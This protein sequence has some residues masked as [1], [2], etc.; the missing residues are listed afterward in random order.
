MKEA[1]FFIIIGYLSGSILFAPLFGKLLRGRD[2]LTE[3]SDGNPGAANAFKYG[4]FWCGVLTLCGDMAKGFLPMHFYLRTGGRP[5]D[6]GVAACGSVPVFLTGASDQA[7]FLQNGV[8]LSGSK[9]RGKRTCRGDI[10][11]EALILSCSTGGGHNA[12][13]LAVKEEMERQCR[14]ENLY[15]CG[16]NRIDQKM[17]G[18]YRIKR[19]ISE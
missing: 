3:S 11:M 19:G 17:D 2:V 15:F 10:F 5:D 12:A 6:T 9:P 18:D 7:A 4:G 1:F 8:F 13:A 16:I 14:R